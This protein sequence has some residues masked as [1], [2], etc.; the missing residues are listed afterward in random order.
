[1]AF[2]S[3]C[4]FFEGKH[5]LHTEQQYSDALLVLCVL[6]K[7]RINAVKSDEIY[8][9]LVDELIEGLA[10]SKT[11]YQLK[12]CLV[13]LYFE[14]GAYSRLYAQF[15]S[16]DIKNI[17]Y[18][19]L[20]YPIL[21]TCFNLFGIF[22]VNTID[23]IKQ[24]YNFYSNNLFD[25]TN[26]ICNCYKYGTFVKLYDIYDFNGSMRKSL[27][28]HQTVYLN[29]YIKLNTSND[30][31]PQHTCALIDQYE[32]DLRNLSSCLK[33]KQTPGGSIYILDTASLIDHNDLG[34]IEGI[35][36]DKNET[37]YK[38][39]Y[40]SVL[41]E[42]KV[43]LA[44]RHMYIKYLHCQAKWSIAGQQP[45]TNLLS[46]YTNAFKEFLIET[47]A[48]RLCIQDNEENG[49]ANSG[50]LNEFKTNYL[51]TYIKYGF[52]N[53]N[54]DFFEFIA[55]MYVQL[56]TYFLTE[57]ANNN[58]RLIAISDKFTEFCSKYKVNL[59]ESSVKGTGYFGSNVQLIGY[60]ACT[61]ELLTVTFYLLTLS[62]QA[63]GISPIW[64]EK[65]KKAK[66]K[67]NVYTDVASGFDL[68]VSLH[69][70]LVGLYEFLI[71]FISDHVKF[72]VLTTTD[73]TNESK[74][75]ADIKQS[76]LNT[77]SS[78]IGQFEI[79]LKQLQQLAS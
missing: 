52:F 63:P 40:A 14:L 59:H 41:N 31:S 26:A 74:T 39:R 49:D 53:I 1:M 46:E 47:F 35:L 25:M 56:P 36:D 15:D 34:I 48:S 2:D 71:S 33:V 54:L 67:K 20:S 17:Q 69:T 3:T 73:A 11:N 30:L 66:K 43:L 4:I 18:Y 9:E 19:S 24:V 38:T 60:L 32:N 8:L 7:F 79:K 77:Y 62:I 16:M 75:M 72:S 57:K 23:F 65:C 44:Y 55:D 50:F 61:Y 78:L 76:Y 22:D 21:F 70:N 6:A 12:F 13:Y 68:F 64:Q 29:L 27:S 10:C 51:R 42:N 5:L 28:L 58:G 45:D 37:L